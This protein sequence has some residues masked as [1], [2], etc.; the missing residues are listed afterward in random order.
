[1]D[2]SKI[3]PLTEPYCALQ[4]IGTLMGIFI[5]FLILFGGVASLFFLLVG[6]IKY[7]TSGD[8]PK[9]TAEARETLTWSVIGLVVI[10]GAYAFTRWLAEQLGVRF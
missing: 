7:I 6:A 4:Q 9:A 8:N 1:M 2:C 10:A 5:R 3:N